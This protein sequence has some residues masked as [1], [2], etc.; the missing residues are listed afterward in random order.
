[1]Q[2]RKT[3]VQMPDWTIGQCNKRWSR[4]KGIKR[5]LTYGELANGFCQDHWD[6]LWDKDK[7]NE[8]QNPM[9]FNKSRI[10]IRDSMEQKREGG[11]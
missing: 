9:G 4:K 8:N 7:R 1:M 11:E 5:C 2:T 6:S 10:C 3:T